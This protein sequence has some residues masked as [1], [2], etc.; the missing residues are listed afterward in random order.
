MTTLLVAVATVV[1]VLVARLLARLTRQPEVVFEIALCLAFGGL[2]LPYVEWGGLPWAGP[3]DLGLLGQAGHLGVALFLVGTAHGMRAGLDR[4]LMRAVTCLSVGSAVVPLATGGLVAWWL[5]DSGD[6]ALR[7]GAPA[8]AFTLM[9]AVALTVTAVPVLAGILRDRRMEHTEEG[10]LALLSASGIDV[11]T[12]VLLAIALGT[13][14]SGGPAA[15][16]VVLVAGAGA[17]LLLRRLVPHSLAGRFPRAVPVVV[18][19]IAWAAATATGRFGLTEVFGA[20]LVGLSLPAEEG[21]GPWARV[22]ELLGRIGRTM[23]PVLFVSTGAAMALA[24]G[25]TFSWQAAVA[26]TVVA[27]AAK[28]GGSYAG[29]RVGGRSPASGMR[30]AVLM[31]T[32]GL[33]EI[34]ILQAGY[35]AG[36]LPAGLYLAF[37]LMALFTT[38]LSGVLLNV[39]DRYVPI[40]KGGLMEANIT[41]AAR[42]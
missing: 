32:R 19:A 41:P 36:L 24:P 35:S 9:V 39:A 37:L 26:I 27:I 28:V 1:V 20:V 17:A 42:W 21:P 23:L 2:L 38:G 31:N 16:L 3:P 10:R 29:A 25:S 34:V 8:G 15:A 40:A 18:G 6:P 30:I 4:R 22:A 14:H 12:W 11:V 33:T 5:I 7:G 13:A